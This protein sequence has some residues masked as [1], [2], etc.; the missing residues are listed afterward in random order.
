[1]STEVRA[2]KRLRTAANLHATSATCSK[3]NPVD[4]RVIWKSLRRT[5]WTSKPPSTR[6]LDNL[7]RYVR[8]G[9]DPNGTD[10]QD[11][12]LGEKA[13]VDHFNAE[14]GAALAASGSVESEA[15]TSS[16]AISCLAKVGFALTVQ[17]DCLVQLLLH[18]DREDS[19]R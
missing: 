15:D 17:D 13:L 8:P 2:S 4:F 9:G 12:F 16:T 14:H 1:M 11:Y 3:D 10:G 5:G 18:L 6:S 19:S 7:Y